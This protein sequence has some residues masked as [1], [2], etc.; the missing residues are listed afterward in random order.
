MTPLKQICII[1]SI[2]ILKI[3]NTCVD[4]VIVIKNDL[5]TVERT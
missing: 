4:F 2:L 3:V 1:S 5:K